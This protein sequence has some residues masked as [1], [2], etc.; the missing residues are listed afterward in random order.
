ML[1]RVDG[2]MTISKSIRFEQWR[3]NERN[4]V[5]D[6]SQEEFVTPTYLSTYISPS[7]NLIPAHR[8]Q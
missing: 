1:N 7:K 3:I 5:I 4:P 6:V 2:V 8:G